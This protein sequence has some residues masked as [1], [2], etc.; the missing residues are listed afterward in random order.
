MTPT[1][2]DLDALLRTP[3][4]PLAPPP[5]A[6]L[7]IRRRSRRL[8]AARRATAVAAVAAVV[9][10]IV[11]PAAV[12][13]H[14]S[15]GSGTPA[16]QPGRPAASRQTQSGWPAPD[17]TTYSGWRPGGP[18]EGLQPLSVSFVDQQTGYLLGRV[19][20][21]LQ[22]AVTHD[23]GASWSAMPGPAASGGATVVRALDG[24]RFATERIGFLF[25]TTFWLTTDAG[26]RWKPLPTPGRITDIEVAGGGA[27]RLWAL[28]QQCPRACGTERL[29]TA[30]VSDPRFRL[31]PDVSP[32]PDGWAQLSLTADGQGVFVLAN[33]PQGGPLRFSSTD[34]GRTWAVGTSAPCAHEGT[35]AALPANH[36]AVVCSAPGRRGDTSRRFV[37][38]TRLNRLPHHRSSAHAA[39]PV[40]DV[41]GL[42]ANG[43]GGVVVVDGFA[44]RHGSG[45]PFQV[46][47]DAGRSWQPAGPHLPHGADFAGYIS[48]QRVVALSAPA[49]HAFLASNDGGLSWRVTSFEH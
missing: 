46:S 10:A 8:R 47:R 24:V 48:R 49:G 31:V 22:L 13:L 7:D 4:E 15:A 41:M 39:P 17:T 38:L 25:G 32:L 20:R 44:T 33:R 3:V 12:L 37:V 26:S 30:P 18:L 45:A 5:G 6:W 29:Y 9:S 19:G 43:I 36:A 35:I 21:R 16:G 23:G 34:G 28:A 14:R 42:T 1:G 2:H 40:G 27:G 11:V